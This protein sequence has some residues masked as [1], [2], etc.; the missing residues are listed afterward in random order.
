MPDIIDLGEKARAKYPGQFDDLSNWQLGKNIKEANPGAY[1]EYDDVPV[2]VTHNNVKTTPRSFVSKAIDAAGTILGGAASTV[3]KKV[4]SPLAQQLPIDDA[5]KARLSDLS[6]PANKNTEYASRVIEQILPG[7]FKPSPVKT[8]PTTVIPSRSGTP[9]IADVQSMLNTAINIGKTGLRVATDVAGDPLSYIGMGLNTRLGRLLNMAHEASQAGEVIKLDSPLAK[10]IAQETGATRPSAGMVQKFLRMIPAKGFSGQVASGERSL[11]SLTNPIGEGN[12][13]LLTGPTA[14]K[15]VAPLDALSKAKAFKAI[16]GLVRNVF[17]TQSG[18]PDFDVLISKAKSVATDRAG[19]AIEDAST[20]NKNLQDISRETGIP[21]E[22]LNNQ[23][24]SI[25]EQAIPTT[26][27][28]SKQKYGSV[29]YDALDAHYQDKL[30]DSKIALTKAQKLNDPNAVD[31]AAKQV[32]DYQGELNK[33]HGRYTPPSGINPKLE[34]QVRRVKAAQANQLLDQEA[35]G[36]PSKPLSADIEYMTHAMTNETRESMVAQ[37]E[38]EGRQLPKQRGKELS[39]E[40]ANGIRRQIVKVKPVV[41]DGWKEAGI[42]SAKDARFIKGKNGIDKLDE[43]LDSGRITADQYPDAVHTLSIQ[44]VQDLPIEMKRKIFGDAITPDTQIFHNDPVYASAIR[45]VKGARAITGA[46]FFNSMKERGLALPEAKAPAD[47]VN[48]K[49]AELAGHK[50]EPQIARVLNKWNDF[51]TNPKEFQDALNAYDRFHGLTKAWTLG[52]FPGY[53]TKNMVGNFW[54]NWLAGLNN[55]QRYEEARRIQMPGTGKVEFEN[56]LGGKWTNANIEKKAKELG[57]IG[58]GQFGGDIQH[59][60][61]QA[62]ENDEFRWKDLVTPSQRNYFLKKGFQVG[63][64]IEDNARIAHFIDRLRKGDTAEAAALSVKKYLFDYGDLT[65]VERKVLNRVFFFYTFTRKNIPL[66][67]HSL[68]TTP[69]K[70]GVPYKIKA[71]VEQNTPNAPEKYLQEYMKE[72]FPTRIRY[73]SKNKKYE[74]FMLNNW[75]PAADLLKIVHL[76]EVAA[77]SLAPIPKEILQQLW[78]YDYY[79]KSKISNIPGTNLRDMILGADNARMFNKDMPTKLVHAMKAIR[80]LNEMDKM[81]KSDSDLFTK[82]TGLLLGKNQTFDP[83]QARVQNAIRVKNDIEDLTSQLYREGNKKPMNRA[84]I[85]KI[86]AM[87]RE[88]AKE[89]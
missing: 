22:D 82:V 16:D 75:L 34:D 85:Q 73:D 67:L 81:T 57:V 49:T 41:V 44:D 20:L 79:Y 88:K 26:K 35:A 27:A 60:I 80:L 76:H 69:W 2:G 58:Q 23:F 31:L 59:T 39:Q 64:G 74:Y 45:A 48:V 63:K 61:K 54:N 51:V 87:I 53:H 86:R 17:S 10:A 46:E 29:V 6:S 38:K 50:V 62:I 4:L 24:N 25:A 5:A 43:L 32:A 40:L 18:N 68:V 15:L 14:A 33:L 66:Q 89:Y 19:L 13:P 70:F 28:L 1:D 77:Q 9:V 47:W 52:I 36:L 84:E 72:N 30:I 11:L 78:N 42:I 8:L 12:I 83:Q 55:P 56:V 37:A 7:V 71:E 65:D 3:T 21:R